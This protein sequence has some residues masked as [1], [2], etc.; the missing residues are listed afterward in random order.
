MESLP[1]LISSGAGNTLD[2]GLEL[3]SDGPIVFRK[4][5]IELERPAAAAP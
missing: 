2:F 4:R 3:Q 5:L 1:G